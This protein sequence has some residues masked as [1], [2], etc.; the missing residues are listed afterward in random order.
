VLELLVFV[1]TVVLARALTAPVVRRV[2]SPSW[3]ER[4][5]P[6]QRPGVPVVTIGG[7]LLVMGILYLIGERRGVFGVVLLLLWIG[8]PV[9]VWT[10]LARWWARDPVR[11][12]LE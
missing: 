3:F 1:V 5:R 2:P 10:V 8:I 11:P 9:F 6:R 7:G 4:L 12:P